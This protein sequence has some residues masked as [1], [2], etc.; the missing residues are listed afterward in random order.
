MSDYHPFSTVCLLAGLASR[1]EIRDAE[2]GNEKASE[3]SCL[4]KLA[5]GSGGRHREKIGVNF[6]FLF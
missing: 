3:A 5:L 4:Q 2:T 6:C 1:A